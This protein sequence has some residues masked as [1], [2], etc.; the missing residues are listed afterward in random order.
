MKEQMKFDVAAADELDRICD[1]FGEAIR[2][3]TAEG[4]AQWDEFYPDR[5]L[6]RA[7]I[8]SGQM[9]VLRVGEQIAAAYSVNGEYDPAEYDNGDWKY[10]GLPFT[11]VHRLCVNPS[12][13]RR[14]IATE[15]MRHIEDCAKERGIECIRLAAF[16]SN[17]AALGLY[18]KLGYA[19]PGEFCCRTGRFYLFEKRI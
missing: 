8:E 14:G 11:V 18:K 17:P 3:M 4:I 6:L 1:I 9:R 16:D 10:P 19:R 2:L 13:R 7:D 5:E 15:V 12:F